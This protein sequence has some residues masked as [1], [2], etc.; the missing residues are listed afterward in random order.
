MFYIVNFCYGKKVKKVLKN[1]LVKCTAFFSTFLGNYRG[2]FAPKVDVFVLS[3][4]PQKSRLVK[5]T[6]CGSWRAFSRCKDFLFHG[7]FSGGSLCF[8]SVRFLG[9]VLFGS[10]G[11]VLGAVLRHPWMSR[12]RG[13]RDFG[14]F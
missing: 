5:Q 12:G 1:T 8:A 10:S 7:R 13:L 11:I 4:K 3:E 2:R 6:E 9:C 14:H